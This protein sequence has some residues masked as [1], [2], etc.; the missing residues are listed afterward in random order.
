MFNF[1]KKA[2]AQL[3]QDVESELR[4]DPSVTFDQIRVTADDGVVTLRGSVPHNSEKTSAERAA[5]RVGGVRAVA[6]ELEVNLFPGFE[7][8]DEEIAHSALAALGWNYSVPESVK[9]TVEK[10][11]VTL[12]GEAEWEYERNAARVAVASLMGVRGVRNEITI[13]SRVQASD[14][15]TKIEEAL[16]RSAE[17]EGG[18]INVT[19]SGSRVS[20]SGRVQSFSELEDARTA[21]WSAPGVTMVDDDLEIAA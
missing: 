16:K 13:K 21:A 7:R 19:V 9:V 4:W 5:Q 3:K 18:N 10:G 1:H 17:T 6:D 2:D 14:V 8:T 20:L 12:R 11:F 15:K